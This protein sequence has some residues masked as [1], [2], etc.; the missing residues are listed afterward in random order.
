MRLVVSDT[1]PLT[2]LLQIGRADLLVELF[3]VVIIPPAVRAELLHDHP[4]LPEWLETIDP[5]EVPTSVASAGLDQGEAQ[6]IS[7]AL[8]L[9][10]DFLLIDELKGRTFAEA[11]GLRVTGVLGVLLLA[12]DRGCIAAVVPLIYELR[13]VAGCWFSDQL[14]EMVRLAAGE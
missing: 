11:R 13:H 14:V 1:S 9:R 8:E 4:Q 6:A 5:V 2:G 7:L 3:E 12:K 10:P